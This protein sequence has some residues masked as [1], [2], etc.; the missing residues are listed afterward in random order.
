[1]Q[2]I[3]RASG[4]RNRPR[5]YA[6]P[7]RITSTS[8]CYNQ[9]SMTSPSPRDPKAPEAPKRTPIAKGEVSQGQLDELLDEIPKEASAYHR[10]RLEGLRAGQRHRLVIAL[11]A[12][13]LIASSTF[14]YRIWQKSVESARFDIPFAHT[15]ATSE[16]TQMQWND[17]KARLGLHRDGIQSILLP[18]RVLSLA[19]DCKHA[20]VWVEVR[21]GKTVEL[22]KVVGEIQQRAR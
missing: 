13:A 6:G 14:A 19:P 4:R 8:L 2:F 17:G 11:A 7:S 18:D 5:P 3:H 1:M 16:D 12:L 20:Q 21:G 10:G 15:P 22:R 9:K